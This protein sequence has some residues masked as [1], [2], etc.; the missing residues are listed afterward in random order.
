M[1]QALEVGFAPFSL[2]VFE[3]CMDILQLQ[4]LAKVRF[5][6]LCIHFIRDLEWFFQFSLVTFLSLEIIK[7][8]FY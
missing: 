7:S 5:I 2:Y 8:P 3:R 4:Q 6:I 1:F